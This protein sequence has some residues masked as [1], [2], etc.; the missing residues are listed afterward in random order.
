GGV[1][2]V[3]HPLPLAAILENPPLAQL[4]QVAGD[5]RLA[6][7]EGGGELADAQFLLPEDQQQAAEAGVVG[8]G[9]VEGDGFHGSARLS[10]RGI[11]YMEIRMAMGG[12]TADA[13]RLTQKASEVA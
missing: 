11:I 13:G 2:A 10:M 4:G 12:L 1:E 6:L 5:L 8:Q 7:A 9:L 3:E